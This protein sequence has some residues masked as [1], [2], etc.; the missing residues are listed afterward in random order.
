MVVVVKFI[1]LCLLIQ[2]IANLTNIYIR[3]KV[4][5][6]DI[7]IMIRH[8]LEINSADVSEQKYYTR[9]TKFV[10]QISLNLIVDYIWYIIIINDT[11]QKSLTYNNPILFNILAWII[12]TD[13]IINFVSYNNKY[14]IFNSEPEQHINL[15]LISISINSLFLLIAFMI[16]L[17]R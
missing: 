4:W 3:I 12:L 13:F 9:L 7:G 1:L 17:W 15:Q 11:V 14:L 6:N 10:G 5:N 16:I 8:Q 2:L